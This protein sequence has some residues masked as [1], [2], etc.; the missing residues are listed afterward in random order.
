MPT[1]LCRGSLLEYSRAMTTSE[2]DII[3]WLKENFARNIPG[4]N[5]SQ[6]AKY[7]GKDR[8][9]MTEILAGR[10]KISVDEYS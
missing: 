6:L 8:S 2:A 4:K 3:V 9:V 10:R 7:L 5:Q 1:P